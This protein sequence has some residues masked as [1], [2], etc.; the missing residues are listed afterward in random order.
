VIT[1]NEKNTTVGQF[2]DTKLIS[3]LRPIVIIVTSKYKNVNAMITSPIGKLENSPRPKDVILHMASGTLPDSNLGI[4][5]PMPTAI[6]IV[7]NKPTK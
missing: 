4:K 2:D 5:F 7:N 6:P 1:N 3:F